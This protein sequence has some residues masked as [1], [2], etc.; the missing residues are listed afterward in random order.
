ME[1]CPYFEDLVTAHLL[2]FKPTLITHSYSYLFFYS[3]AAQWLIFTK[4][5]TTPSAEPGRPSGIGIRPLLSTE[6]GLKARTMTLVSIISG[7]F[8]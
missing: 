5:A 7:R 1:E 6:T 3:I 8:P 4:K 2:N